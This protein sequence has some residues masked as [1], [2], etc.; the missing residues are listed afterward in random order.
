MLNENNF[1]LVKMSEKHLKEVVEIAQTNR[2][3]YWSLD[4]YQEEISRKDSYC[5]ISRNQEGNTIGF[6]V[7]RLIMSEECG[8][9]YNI[10]VRDEAK[11]QG[12][13]KL[14][15]S[16]F[17]KYCKDKELG[18]I[19]LEVRESNQA[20]ISFYLKMDFRVVG[21]RKN[22]YSFP[23]ENAILMTRYLAE[24]SSEF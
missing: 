19:H 5:L 18:K 9:I 4:D 17:I 12:V 15:L 3:S 23:A 11:H 2:L 22:F 6:I 1:K 13:G 14:M 8:E 21:I 16:A 7:A 24:Q 10:A 20:A